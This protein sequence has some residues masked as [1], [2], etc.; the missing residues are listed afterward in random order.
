MGMTLTCPKCGRSIAGEDISVKDGFAQCGTCRS[1]FNLSELAAQRG[2]RQSEPMPFARKSEVGMP[3]NFEKKTDF[4]GLTIVRKWRDLTAFILIPFSIFWN[5]FLAVWISI[6]IST[7]EYI[8]IAFAS[9][10]IAAGVF[11][12]YSGIAKMINRTTVKV[13]TGELT[14]THGPV[15]WPSPKPISHHQVRQVYG[16]ERVSRS[17]RGGT[18]VRYELRTLTT[19]GRDIKLLSGLNDRAQ[20]L[21]LEQEIERYWNISDERVGGEMV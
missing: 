21:F 3:K 6:A 7:G 18:S 9:I 5:G 14:I 13:S 2:N 20:V 15:P 11:L 12:V 4:D 1:V 8:M 10:H 19:D 17:S 16:K